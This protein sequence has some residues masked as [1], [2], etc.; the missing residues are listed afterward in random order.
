ML[1]D[2]ARQIYDNARTHGF[3]DG[4]RNFGETLPCL[5]CQ[6]ADRG[7]RHPLRPWREIAKEAGS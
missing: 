2:L 5:T 1:N 7:E 3:W 4:A 6:T